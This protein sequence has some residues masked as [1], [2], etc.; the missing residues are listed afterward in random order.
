[1]RYAD[2]SIGY[3]PSVSHPAKS[4]PG[5]TAF[6]EQNHGAMLGVGDIR[7][8]RREFRDAPA[9][10]VTKNLRRK[11]LVLTFLPLVSAM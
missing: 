2:E 6:A 11:F 10:D 4:G 3:C 8:W 7:I 1:M 5:F 9:I